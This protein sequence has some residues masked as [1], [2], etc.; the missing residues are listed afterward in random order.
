MIKICEICGKEFEPGYKAYTRKYCYECSP[1]QE[2]NKNGNFSHQQNPIRVAVKKEL[3]KYKGGKCE[4]CG[5]NK[6]IYALHFHHIDPS[7]KDFS[8]SEYFK[9]NSKIDMDLFKKEVDKCMLVCANC[10]A[11]LHEE[12]GCVGE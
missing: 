7:I 10:H 12:M 3:I 11:E 8:I 6:S 1:K 4:R 5:Y 2:K 9:K